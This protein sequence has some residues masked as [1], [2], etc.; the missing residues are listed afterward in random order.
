MDMQEKKT[1]KN[2]NADESLAELW[3]SLVASYSML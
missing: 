1:P 3:A 2:A